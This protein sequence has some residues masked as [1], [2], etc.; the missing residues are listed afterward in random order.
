LYETTKDDFL[1]G[2]KRRNAIWST[3]GRRGGVANDIPIC[4]L[5]NAIKIHSRSID[6][7]HNT[8]LPEV[9]ACLYRLA[10]V[11]AGIIVTVLAEDCGLT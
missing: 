10:R 7:L 5:I 8:A 11:G 6:V 2:I 1:E 3:L 9:N 4:V